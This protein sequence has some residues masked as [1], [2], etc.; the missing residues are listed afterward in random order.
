MSA[1]QSRW[2]FGYGSLI[3]RPAIPF[4]ERRL[5][6]LRGW[7]RRFWQWSTD[8]RGTPWQPGRVVTLALAPND[9]C[10]GVAYRLDAAQAD[11]ILADLDVRERGGYVRM[12][13]ELELEE[14]VEEAPRSPAPAADGRRRAAA[15]RPRILSGIV[16]PRSNT[17]RVAGVTYQGWPGNRNYAGPAPLAEIAAQISDARG[18]SGANVD[19]VRDL[20]TALNAL[21]VEDAHVAALAS[22]LGQEG[23]G[24]RSRGE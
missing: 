10:W 13:V 12:E 23:C 4:V 22:G 17:A 1:A 16:A 8:H 9:C 21:G 20:H 7:T 2:I 11:A 18:P 6:C 14:L 19:Y 24:K 5:A 3:F 15:E